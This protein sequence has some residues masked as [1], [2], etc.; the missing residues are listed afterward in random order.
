MPLNGRRHANLRLFMLFTLFLF[1]GEN[2][3]FAFCI[4]FVMVHP[5]PSETHR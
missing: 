4:R 2:N 5:V 1:V 3:S